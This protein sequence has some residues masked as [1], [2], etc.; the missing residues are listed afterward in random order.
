MIG[1]KV[2]AHFSSSKMINEKVVKREKLVNKVH[3]AVTLY[4]HPVS[5][6]HR[7]AI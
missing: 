2:Y 6:V 7:A 4:R 3:A 1:F 5:Q